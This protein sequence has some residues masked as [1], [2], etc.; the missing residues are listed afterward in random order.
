[1]ARSSKRFPQPP[2]AGCE[3]RFVE[4]DGRYVYVFADDGAILGRGEASSPRVIA[5]LLDEFC[6]WRANISREPA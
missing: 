6:R 1:M 4:V 2:Y 5:S 3:S